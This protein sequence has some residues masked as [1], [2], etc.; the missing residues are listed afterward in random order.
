MEAFGHQLDTY[1]SDD[2][3][4]TRYEPS[5]GRADRLAANIP[6]GVVSDWGFNG[7]HMGSGL[8]GANN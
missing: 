4:P 8:G 7:D 6:G 5:E 1:L 2:V 3:T